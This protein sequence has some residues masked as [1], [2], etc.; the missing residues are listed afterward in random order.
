METYDELFIAIRRTT[1]GTL[2]KVV[3]L[4][5]LDGWDD[6]KAGMTAALGDEEKD[7]PGFIDQEDIKHL[8]CAHCNHGPELHAPEG[9]CNH[10]TETMCCSCTNY[11]GVEEMPTLRP[12]GP[13]IIVEEITTE[14]ADIKRAEDAG[15][16]IPSTVKRI[17]RS[18]RGMVIAI[19]DD[20]ILREAFHLEEG[21]IVWFAPTAGLQKFVNG[22]RLRTL[23][24]HELTD[25]EMPD[26]NTV[27]TTTQPLKPGGWKG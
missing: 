17:S 26:I 20:P 14:D 25:V 8:T 22:R 3:H 9:S 23:E 21:M 27:L 24:A 13:R 7:E 18:S 4:T 2:V 5:H 19:G 6:Y 16:A 15:L 11:E 12:L 1:D 10:R